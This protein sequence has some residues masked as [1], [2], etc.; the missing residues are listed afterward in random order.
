MP[1]PPGAARFPEIASYPS[2][3]PAG[4][5]KRVELDFIIM[6]LSEFC[7]RAFYLGRRPVELPSSRV[8]GPR[9][10]RPSRVHWP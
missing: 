3:R 5:R 8:P 9:L 4:R 7:Q 10:A 6:A 2:R 1:V